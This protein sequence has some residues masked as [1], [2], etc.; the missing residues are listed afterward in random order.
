MSGRQTAAR[1]ASEWRKLAREGPEQARRRG[2]RWLDARAAPAHGRL[3]RRRRRVGVSLGARRAPASDLVRAIATGW[4]VPLYDIEPARH[5]ERA[6]ICVGQLQGI[7]T[8]PK[9]DGLKG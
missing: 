8:H 2:A 5:A 7:E 6:F 1:A 3:L 4:L 9:H